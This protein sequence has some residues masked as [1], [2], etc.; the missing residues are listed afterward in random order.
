MPLTKSFVSL[1]GEKFV[2]FVAFEVGGWD[3]LFDEFILKIYKSMSEAGDI[4]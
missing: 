1:A 4:W 3:A 2:F